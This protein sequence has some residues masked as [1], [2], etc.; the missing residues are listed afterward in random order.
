M[1]CKIAKVSQLMSALL[2]EVIGFL[3]D[4]VCL[5]RFIIAGPSLEHLHITNTDNLLLC[6]TVK[7]Y[8]SLLLAFFV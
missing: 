4:D 3:V 5:D 6:C 1:Q 8:L 2:V 7:D